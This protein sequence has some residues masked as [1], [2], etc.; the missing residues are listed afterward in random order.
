M[1]KGATYFLGILTGI[2]VSVATFFAVTYFSSS[3]GKLYMSGDRGKAMKSD[4]FTIISTED[5]YHA[6]A[7]SNVKLEKLFDSE[8]KV[9]YIIGNEK[10]QFYDG[11]EIKAS[12]KTKFYQVGTYKYKTKED[13]WRTVPAVMLLKEQ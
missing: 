3:S 5:N 13:E 2:A 7:V 11:Y 9:V 4:S 12:G 8:P 1:S 10:S 6:L